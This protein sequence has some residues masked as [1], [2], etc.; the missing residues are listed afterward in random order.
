MDNEVLTNEQLNNF[1]SSIIEI[2]LLCDRLVEGNKENFSLFTVKYQVLYLIK[3]NGKVTPSELVHKLNMAK[4][5]IALLAKKMI[6]EGL[7]NSIKEEDNKKQI[8]YVLTDK[9][10][11]E[12]DNCL[13]AM[14]KG[15]EFNDEELVVLNRAID[16]LKNKIK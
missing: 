15:K 14:Q 9:G 10:E 5:N 12:T 8:Y 16:I 3:S 7:I 13:L 2:K 1:S 6:N 11:R 4:S